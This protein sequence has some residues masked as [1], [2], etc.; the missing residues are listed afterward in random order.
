MAYQYICRNPKCPR[1]DET[2]QREYSPQQWEARGE[3][4]PILCLSCGWAV[5]FLGEAPAACF[6]HGP[7]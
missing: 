6:G 7:L 1:H 3:D 5:E 4:L 2:Q